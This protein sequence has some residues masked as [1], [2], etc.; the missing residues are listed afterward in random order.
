MFWFMQGL[1]FLPAFLV[2]W[3]SSTF[4]VN[5]IIAI[6]RKDVDVIFPYISDTGALPPESCL[7]GL[8]TFISAFAA[9]TMYARYK[10]VEKLSEETSLVRPC[11]NKAA[12]GL[13]MLACLGMCIVATFQETT[14]TRVHDAGAVLFFLTGVLYAIF[15]SVISHRIYPFGSSLTVC[16]IRTA[17][18]TLACLAF[19][20]SIL[21]H[22]SKLHK[23]QHKTSAVSEWIVAFSFV[24]FFLT[25]I[26]E[27]KV[28][29]FV[30]KLHITLQGFYT[31]MCLVRLTDFACFCLVIYEISI[32]G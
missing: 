11:L 5:Y 16:R 30:S 17:I 25:Y 23:Y 4:I 10:Y 9:A 32:T 14:V 28:S 31:I 12:L 27:F 6:F 29:V 24:C 18:A 22:S 26:D 19:F 7:F 1:C 20:P 15:Q 2:I 21:S 13:G 3:S 8:M